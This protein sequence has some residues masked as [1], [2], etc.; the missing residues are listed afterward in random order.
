[1][2]P[3]N[4]LAVVSSAALLG[5]GVMPAP[6]IAADLAAAPAKAPGAAKTP[7]SVMDLEMCK[8]IEVADGAAG[9]RPLSIAPA[10]KATIAKAALAKAQA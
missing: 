10:D 7:S 1:M 4:I 6:A 9:T 5:F 2:H 3:S 8:P